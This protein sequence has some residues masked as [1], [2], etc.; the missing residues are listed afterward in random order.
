LGKDNAAKVFKHLTDEEIEQITLEI[1]NVKKVDAATKNAVVQEFCDTY[2]AQNYILEGGIDYAKEILDKAIGQ[3]K[4]YE[5][6]NKLT[7][8][9]QVRPFDF[10][11]KLDHT[12]LLN[13]IQNEHPQTIALILSYLDA[14]QSGAVL[15]SLPTDIQTDVIARIAQMGRTSPEHIKEVE[16]ILE[17]KL[18]SLG[19]SDYTKVGGINTSVAILNAV[20]R[21]T[22]K[23]IIEALEAQNQEL[24]E[25]I[26][27]RMF[28]FED[29]T[30]LN[31][32]SIQRV[33]RDVSNE[34]LA[35]ALKG[36]SNEVAK[37]IFENMSQRLQQMIKDDMEVMG[38]VRL[39]DVEEAQQRIVNLI[40]KLDEEG[41]IV[42][43]RGQEELVVG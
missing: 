23:H 40:R 42:I 4:A 38:P 43:I 41:E 8:T 30:K 18:F 5:L 29:I 6:I 25:E 32:I 2:I 20:D 27:S 28:L 22:E 14:K 1:S 37:V 7:S 9:L 24:A 36:V 31:K 34:D 16:R 33:L 19:V 11:S 12:Q 17:K 26:K 35:L 13:L 21:G 3:Q 10:A 39:R 15:S